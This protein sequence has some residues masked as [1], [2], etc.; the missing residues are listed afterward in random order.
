MFVNRFNRYYQFEE[1]P[2]RASRLTSYSTHWMTPSE[3]PRYDA[4][5]PL[6]SPRM[7]SFRM[8]S[9]VIATAG[10]NGDAFGASAAAAAAEELLTAD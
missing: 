4:D 8:M 10:P 6:Y 5:K 3:T 1:T 9:H 2:R 7:P